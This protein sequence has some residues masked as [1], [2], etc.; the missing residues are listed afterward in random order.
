MRGGSPSRLNW[1]E[2]KFRERIPFSRP[3][4]LVFSLP[5]S[6]VP[7]A[8]LSYIFRDN[9]ARA[10]KLPVPV[11]AAFSETRFGMDIP[12]TQFRACGNVNTPS[13]LLPEGGKREF[14]LKLRAR[15]NFCGNKNFRSRRGRTTRR[16]KAR[17]IRL[18]FSPALVSFRAAPRSI[19]RQ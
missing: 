15:R 18:A 6:F 10:H 1:S 4:C 14:F 2:K 8:E 19:I 17:T 13:P 7:A 9:N 16:R 12:K 3:I 11:C 5:V